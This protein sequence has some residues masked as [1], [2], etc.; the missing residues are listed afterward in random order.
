MIHIFVADEQAVVREGV[1]RIAGETPDL[2]VAGEAGD[3]RDIIGNLAAQACDVVLM[4]ITPTGRGGLD[5]IQEIRSRYPRLPIVVFSTHTKHYYVTRVFK[6]GAAG[7]LTKHCS[8][9]ELVTALR[10]VGQG[11]RYVDAVTAEILA[12]EA[13][14]DTE[15]PPHA[16]LSDREF[17]VLCLIGLGKTVTEIAQELWLS[18]KTVSTYRTRILEKMQLKTTADLVHYAIHQQ[19]V[20]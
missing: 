9:G 10:R 4:D 20:S 1:K 7:Y 2:F 12:R 13:S 15:K 8:P 19:L 5:I 16:M 6:A 18:V 11:G 14:M 3:N 17:Q